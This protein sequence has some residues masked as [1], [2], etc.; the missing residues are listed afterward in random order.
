MVNLSYDLSRMDNRDGW[1][2]PH[3]MRTQVDRLRHTILFELIGLITVT[4]LATWLLDRDLAM[5]GT[6]SIF[7]S[8][9][10][11][12]CNYIYNLLFD[13]AL[14]RLGRPLNHRPPKLRALHAILFECSLITITLPV[15]AWWLDMP[16]WHAFVADIGFA[17]FFLFYAYIFNWTY[18]T[19]FPMPVEDHET[20]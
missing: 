5:I 12:V 15:I 2:Y 17:L 20:A 9:T 11:M 7:L 10:A 3:R 14:K 8:L 4:P 1:V 18:D 16:L 6:M 13:L 19:V